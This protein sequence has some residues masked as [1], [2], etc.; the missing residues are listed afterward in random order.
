MLTRTHARTITQIRTHTYTYTQREAP[1]QPNPQT[2]VQE[3][4]A[5]PVNAEQFFW[6]QDGPNEVCLCAINPVCPTAIV[7]KPVPLFV[8]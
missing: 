6:K 4:I 7:I 8:I 5:D 2:P 3:P 1:P